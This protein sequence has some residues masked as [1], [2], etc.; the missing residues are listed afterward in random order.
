MS[1]TD[2][3]PEKFENENNS[4]VDY[5]LKVVGKTPLL[6]PE[7]ELFLARR[8]K[9]GDQKAKK[10]LA[11][12]NLRLVVSRA[13]KIHQTAL[14]FADLIQE[15]NLGLI[16]AVNAFDPDLDYKFSTFATRCIDNEMTHAVRDCGKTIRIPGWVQELDFHVQRLLDDY[17]VRNG[18][19]PELKVLYS[20]LI[21]SDVKI[22]GKSI[23]LNQ[24]IGALKGIKVRAFLSSELGIYD[25]EDRTRDFLSESIVD[26]DSI[27]S[28]D[29]LA[30]VELKEVLAK[31]TKQR[32]PEKQR[33]ILIKLYGLDGN[34]PLTQVEIGLIFSVGKERIRQIGE[35]ALEALSH[36][37]LLREYLEIPEP[38]T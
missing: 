10:E 4:S 19:E 27:D 33:S 8:A 31:V 26:P 7:E 13:K 35:K 37:P 5:W 29:Y 24:L 9:G 25:D 30:S 36:D 1:E 32:L 16:K 20:L 17:Y 3:A 28:C 15:G 14:S 21:E 34:F 22:G 2:A 11:E 18:C 38:K 23:S 6:T 12:A